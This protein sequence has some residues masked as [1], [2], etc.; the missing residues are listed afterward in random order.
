MR[1]KFKK[2]FRYSQDHF[3]DNFLNLGYRY[4]EKGILER[5]VSP[6]LYANPAHDGTYRQL[7]KL[8]VHLVNSV[9]RIK[10]QYSIAH[11]KDSI[12]I[13]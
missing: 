9:K 7:D 1:L 11:D 5:V 6:E 4:W 10:T 2:S 3:R 13:N 12:L 8:L